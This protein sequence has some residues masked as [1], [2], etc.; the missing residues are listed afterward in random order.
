MWLARALAGCG[1]GTGAAIVTGA[2]AAP[3]PDRPG[4]AMTRPEGASGRFSLPLLPAVSA[5]MRQHAPPARFASYM[6][7]SAWASRLGR[8]PQRPD[9]AIPTLTVNETGVPSLPVTRAGGPVSPTA[10]WVALR[11]VVP[12]IIIMNSSP[13]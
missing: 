9:S 6:A 8:S 1:T 11:A 12:G 3:S 5:E 13:P 2:A 4:H 7:R 10:T